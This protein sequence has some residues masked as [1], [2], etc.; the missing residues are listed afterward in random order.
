M[1]I[2]LIQR[3]AKVLAQQITM[4]G[5]RCY[6]DVRVSPSFIPFSSFFYSLYFLSFFFIF[7]LC[8]VLTSV[9]LQPSDAYNHKK[10]GGAWLR[11]VGISSSFSSS[12]SPLFFFSFL[13]FCQLIHLIYLYRSILQQDIT[14]G[15]RTDR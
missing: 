11:F 4:L 14:L 9:F 10:P 2:P 12:L 6:S 3:P 1:N 13:F 5:Y 15:G 8:Y 7:F